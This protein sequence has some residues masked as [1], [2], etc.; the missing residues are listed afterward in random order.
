M[1]NTTMGIHSRP[2]FKSLHEGDLDSDYTMFIFEATSTIPKAH[3]IMGD[4]G[5]WTTKEFLD[6]SICL[7][8]S[9]QISEGLS[10]FLNPKLFLDSF[11]S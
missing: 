1:L 2:F 5:V 10:G 6:E 7:V 4:P 11:S 9:S 8:R 3:N